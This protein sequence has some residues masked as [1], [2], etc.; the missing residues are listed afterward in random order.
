MKRDLAFLRISGTVPAEG[1]FS[2]GTTRQTKRK[3]SKMEGRS[4]E[5]KARLKENDMRDKR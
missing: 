4:Q 1:K 3:M 5:E 2:K